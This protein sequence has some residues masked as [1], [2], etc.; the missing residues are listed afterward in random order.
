MIKDKYEI[1]EKTKE[2]VLKSYFDKDSGR[3]KT[4]PNKEKKKVI[5]LQKIFENFES[6]RKYSEKEVNEIVSG[7]YDDIFIIRRL[8]VD[9]GFMRRT[10][11]C[12]EYWVND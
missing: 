6:N 1:D 7:F 11:D 5:V 4:L 12:R 2:K 3:L 10:Q 9:Y 8:L